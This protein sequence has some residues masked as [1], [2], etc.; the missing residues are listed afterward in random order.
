MECMRRDFCV[1]A[2]KDL[3]PFYLY[4]QN[5]ILYILFTH[6]YKQILAAVQRV[7]L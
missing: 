1:K 3:S 6:I 7:A 4:I 2:K 5:V